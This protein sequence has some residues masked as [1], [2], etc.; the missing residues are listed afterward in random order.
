MAG[1]RT[2]SPAPGCCRRR[3]RRR[4]EAPSSSSRTSKSYWPS[5]RCARYP[6]STPVSVPA[7]P[8]PERRDRAA[9]H[10]LA[11]ASGQR[12]EQPAHRSRRWPTPTGAVDDLRA[13]RTR[14]AKPGVLGDES[15]GHGGDRG[16]IGAQRLGQ[17]GGRQ[18][19]LARR[20]GG[21]PAR[22][23]PSRRDRRTA[24]GASCRARLRLDGHDCFCA[25]R[26]G[27]QHAHVVT[28]APS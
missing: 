8:S 13:R 25:P 15:L 16:E 20:R 17:V 9:G 6:S 19:G 18:A 5:T 28:D 21:R 4:R 12:F 3:S 23:G 14:R 7:M 10:S 2:A 26:L 27:P 24:G 11:D 1:T 22:P